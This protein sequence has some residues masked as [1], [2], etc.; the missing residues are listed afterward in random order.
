MPVIMGSAWV[1]ASPGQL[2]RAIGVLLCG[3][4]LQ[5]LR[6]RSGVALGVALEREGEA[7]HG[8]VTVTHVVPEVLAPTTEDARTL[9]GLLPRQ[10][11]A[12]GALGH[13]E[14]AGEPMR[15]L[16]GHEHGLLISLHA[17]T[18]PL[19]TLWRGVARVRDE[20]RGGPWGCLGWGETCRVGV[21][22][23]TFPRLTRGGARPRG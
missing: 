13:L 5:P 23:P 6:H 3:V 7:A 17:A 10:V 12:A 20:G 11:Q 18:I 15:A 14:S 16:E 2:D 8:F 4:A 1:A 21:R 9:G 19:E 22:R